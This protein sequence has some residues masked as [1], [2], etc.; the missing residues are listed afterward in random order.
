MQSI[1]CSTAFSSSVY[2]NLEFNL[3]GISNSTKT[4]P[5]RNFLPTSF[6]SF[7]FHSLSLAH[8]IIFSLLRIVNGHDAKKKKLFICH[9]NV[10]FVNNTK[11]RRRR[12]KLF[13]FF[14][15]AALLCFSFLFFCFSK[16]SLYV[17]RVFPRDSLIF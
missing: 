9:L 12:E 13:V 2:L 6:H 14:S 1:F 11:K 15:F 8:A 5:Q 4:F 10:N 3:S 16:I 7:P 17:L